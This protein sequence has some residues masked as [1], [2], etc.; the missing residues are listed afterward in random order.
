MLGGMSTNGNPIPITSASSGRSPQETVQAF[1]HALEELDSDKILSLSAPDIRWVNAPITTSSNKEQFAKMVRGM[2][3]VVTRFEVQF[4]DIHE[5][6]DGAVYTDRF[7]IIEGRG[8]K[9]KIHVIGEFKVKDGLVTEWVD[10]FSW[11]SVIGDIAKSLPAM[12]RFALKK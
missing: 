9:M 5:L 11:S 7:D 2:L 1:I 12:I 10:R 6:G 3:K 4:R 8:L